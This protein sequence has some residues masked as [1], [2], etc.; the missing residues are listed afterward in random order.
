M[1][2]VRTYPEIK[3]KLINSFV[4]LFENAANSYLS[5][6]E[7]VERVR[8]VTESDKKS[9]EGKKLGFKIEVFDGEH[10]AGFNSYSGG[11]KSRIM[12]AVGFALRELALQRSV[13]SSLGFLLVDELLDNID[14]TG[15]RYFFSLLSKVAG[16]KFLI[17]HTKIDDITV[18]TDCQIVI[19]KQGSESSV[20]VLT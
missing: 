17:T 2:W 13:G 3:R 5:D 6:L 11:E 1:Y 10:W 15:M 12:I 16:Q 20:K 4:P 18:D 9:G 14:S 7:I 19:S 8:F